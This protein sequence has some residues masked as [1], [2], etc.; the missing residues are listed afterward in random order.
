[1]LMSKEPQTL[2]K[3][4]QVRVYQLFGCCQAG[5]ELD[6]TILNRSV[7]SISSSFGACD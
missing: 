6:P 2:T 1:M 4:R 3:K 5:F 7:K